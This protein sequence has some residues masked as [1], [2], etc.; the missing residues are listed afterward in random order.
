MYIIIKSWSSK[1][2]RTIL[3]ASIHLNIK[4][5]DSHLVHSKDLDL[6]QSKISPKTSSTFSCGSPTIWCHIPRYI[7]RVLSLLVARWYNSSTH[8]GSHTTSSL[9]WTIINGMSTSSNLPWTSLHILISSCA[10]AARG[11]PMYL[12]GLEIAS[13]RF[14]S[15]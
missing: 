13:L 3:N 12:F 7:L 9:P 6:S 1:L 2:F 11:F 15:S 8:A 4:G 5:F 10:V 14:H